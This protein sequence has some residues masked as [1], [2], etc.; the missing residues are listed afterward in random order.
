MT[1]KYNYK[2]S[3]CSHEYLEI[4]AAD[5]PQFFTKCNS[6]KNGNYVEESVEVISEKVERLEAAEESL[7]PE[8]TRETLI[9]AGELMQFEPTE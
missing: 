3:L 4:R 6:C 5:E 9:A 7:V 8:V 1:V 2:C